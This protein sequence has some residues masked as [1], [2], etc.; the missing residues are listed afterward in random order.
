MLIGNHYHIY[1]HI[2]KHLNENGIFTIFSI[3]L[4]LFNKWFLLY[5]IVTLLSL[6]FIQIHCVIKKMLCVSIRFRGVTRD[7]LLQSRCF[8]LNTLNVRCFSAIKLILIFLKKNCF[9][10]TLY[11]IEIER[12]LDISFSNRFR[13][14]F[15]MKY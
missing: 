14:W 2:K 8:N 10:K 3:L 7:K 1:S 6:Y 15:R 9:G 13:D 12:Q 11:E 5:L 4:F